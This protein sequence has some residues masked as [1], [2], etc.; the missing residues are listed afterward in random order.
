MDL[1][2]IA[3]Y[4]PWFIGGLAAYEIWRGGH[5]TGLLLSISSLGAI[6]LLTAVDAPGASLFVALAIA[7]LFL[8]CM[9]SET[10]SRL[11]SSNWLTVVGVSSYSLYLLHQNLGITLIAVLARKLGVEGYLS[12]SLALGMSLLMIFFAFLVWRFWEQPLNR[13]IVSAYVRR[14]RRPSSR[15]EVI[16]K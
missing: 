7:G 3:P 16:R 12:I 10:I 9:W 1:L 15:V 6:A 8:L 11:F 13:A 14:G 5:R 4:L 2:L